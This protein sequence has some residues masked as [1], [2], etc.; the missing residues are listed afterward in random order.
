MNVR[1]LPL[2]AVLALSAV[3]SSPVQAQEIERIPLPVTEV[4]AGYTFMRDFSSELP[5]KLSFPAGWY[6][7]AAFNV[8]RWFGLVAEGTGSYKNDFDMTFEDLSPEANRELARM[9]N[10]NARVYTLMSGPRVFRKTGRIMPYAQAL[11]GGAHLRLK[12]QFTPPDGGRVETV[13]DNT[14]YFAVQPGGGVSFFLTDRIGVRVA[15]DY[16]LIVD[17]GDGGDTENLNEFR[18]LTGFNFNWGRR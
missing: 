6:G 10:F 16:R 1:L 8:N 9:F 15:A 2:A 4:S 11:V 12:S 17:V 7:S 3:L 13:N 18:V 5:D 14:T